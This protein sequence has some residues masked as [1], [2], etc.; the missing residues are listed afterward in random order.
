MSFCLTIMF[1]LLW[2]IQNIQIILNRDIMFNRESF[3]LEIDK[4]LYFQRN[5]SEITIPIE[6]F[7]ELVHRSRHPKQFKIKEDYELSLFSFGVF[8]F[9]LG[10]ILSSIITL[11]YCLCKKHLKVKRILN[12]NIM[13][14]QQLEMSEISRN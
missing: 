12:D 4:I 1:K 10:I 6:L 7:I 2:L 14:N 5:R 9:L 13:I 11:I 3:D 8:M